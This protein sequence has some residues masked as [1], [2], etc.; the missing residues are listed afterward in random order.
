MRSACAAVTAAQESLQMEDDIR[1]PVARERAFD[2]PEKKAWLKD[3]AGT[4]PRSRPESP[5]P[6]ITDCT[7]SDDDGPSPV[8][9]SMNIKI[10]FGFWVLHNLAAERHGKG[11]LVLSSREGGGT[12]V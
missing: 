8:V 3:M 10:A 9:P 11:R 12:E 7:D 4:L 2:R 6:V 5:A 1:D